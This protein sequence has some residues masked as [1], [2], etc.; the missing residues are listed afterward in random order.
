MLVVNCWLTGGGE[1]KKDGVVCICKFAFIKSAE[2]NS[3]FGCESTLELLSFS[4]L[5]PL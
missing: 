2:L 4:D 1:K 3:V 5:F